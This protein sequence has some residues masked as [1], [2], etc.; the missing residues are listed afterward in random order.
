MELHI[1][2]RSLMMV[3]LLEEC[4][5]SCAHCVREE[6]PMPSGYRLEHEQLT[7]CLA[8]CASLESVRWV[9][10]SGG[11]PTLW[12]EGEL[13]LADLLLEIDRAG[14]APGF[15]TN[16]VL[17]EDLERCR[18]LLGRV[19]PRIGRPLRLYLSIDTFHRNFDA[20]TGRARC[21]D[22]VIVCTSSM[23]GAAGRMLDLNVLTVVSRDASSLLPDG[24][25][26]H[27]SDLGADFVFTPL[28]R[29]GLARS[30]AHLC[31]DLGSDRPEDLGAYHRYRPERLPEG[32]YGAVANMVL[33]G[34]D[35]YLP[36]PWRKIASLGHLP[37]ELALAYSNDR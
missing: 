11:E 4:N 28:K 10:F 32:D 24:M 12:H 6:E 2:D 7:G 9:H 23:P 25:V 18:D 37:P 19:L 36:D 8:D 34:E 1:A 14:F 22:N 21:L 30:M 26:E 29:K 20:S 13:D 5:L 31:P 3:F 27:Y 17:L 35:Y 33:I 16:G 15:T